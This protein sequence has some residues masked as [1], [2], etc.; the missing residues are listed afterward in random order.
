M[1]S[2]LPAFADPPARVGRVSFVSGEAFFRAD[3]NSEWTQATL[4]YPVTEHNQFATNADARLELSIGSA[5]IRLDED[6]EI[7]IPRLDDEVISVN[8]ERG[9]AGVTVRGQESRYPIEVVTADAS[10]TLNDSGTYRIEAGRETNNTIIT[11]LRGNAGVATSEATLSVKEGREAI[12]TGA[13]FSY[14][15]REAGPHPFDEWT[16]ARD[17]RYDRAPATRYVSP[18]MTGYEELDENGSWQQTAEYGVIWVPRVTVVGWAPYRHGHWAWVAPWGWTW[19][20]AAPWGFAPYHYGRW[21][22]YR[23]AWGW[24]PGPVHVRPVY[25]PALVVW[26][27]QPGW[28]FSFSAGSGP[29]VG[30]FP[31][32]WGEVYRPWYPCSV[33]YVRNVNITNTHIPNIHNVNWS[34][35]APSDGNYALRRFPQAVTVV[36]QQAFAGGK[37]VMRVAEPLRDNTATERLPAATHTAPTVAPIRAAVANTPTRPTAPAVRSANPSQRIRLQDLP[38]APANPARLTPSQPTPRAPGA[39]AVPGRPTVPAA[40][41]PPTVAAPV[42][43]ATP[44]R[45]AEPSRRF[46]QTPDGRTVIPAPGERT[47]AGTTRVPPR[48]TY[49]D[50][51]TDAIDEGRPAQRIAPPNPNIRRMPVPEGQPRPVPRLSAP[52]AAPAAPPPVERSTPPP[53]VERRQPAVQPQPGAAVSSPQRAQAGRSEGQAE[54]EGGNAIGTGRVAR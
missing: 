30:W 8:L 43:P 42:A 13:P 14:R 40:P 4:N 50:P 45:P 10:I 22:H 27:G 9:L 21:V 38:A 44:A 33:N 32:G 2:A 54:G 23:G 15:V 25:A 49:A 31:L 36:P 51:R 5:A 6:S 48:A 26:V 3:P 7:S 35:P 52:P 20:D 17:Q 37:P 18:E 16:M 34:A 11:V 29:A 41:T 53:Q 47:Q 19:V 24:A 28:S 39:P 46:P 1:A 12:V